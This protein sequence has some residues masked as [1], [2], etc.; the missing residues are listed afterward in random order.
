MKNGAARNQA[1]NV[2]KSLNY[3][4]I[5]VAKRGLMITHLG[6][7]QEMLTLK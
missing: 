4:I 7:K 6:G 5:I 2:K 3:Y 1:P